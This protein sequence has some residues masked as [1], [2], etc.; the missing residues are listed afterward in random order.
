MAVFD[1]IMPGISVGA[2]QPQAP[3][4]RPISTGEYLQG[5]VQAANLEVLYQQRELQRQV[6]EQQQKD[7][8]LRRIGLANKITDPV[9]GAKILPE[10]KDQWEEL[11]SRYGLGSG[12]EMLLQSDE[13]L[14]TLSGN[15]NRFF[16]DQDVSQIIGKSQRVDAILS[17]ADKFKK[18][19]GDMYPVLLQDLE[20]AKTSYEDL[21]R[22]QVF[23]YVDPKIEGLYKDYMKDYGTTIDVVTDPETQSKLEVKKPSMTKEEAADVFIQMIADPGAQKWAQAHGYVDGSGNVNP[24]RV[25][26]VVDRYYPREFVDSATND[27]V[28][29]AREKAKVTGSGK[30]GGGSG[31][32]APDKNGRVSGKYTLLNKYE[33]LEQNLVYPLEDL[34]RNIGLDYDNNESVATQMRSIAERVMRSG[35]D[36]DTESVQAYKSILELGTKQKL[37]KALLKGAAYMLVEEQKAGTESEA[38]NLIKTD[39]SLLKKYIFTFDANTD[40]Y[41]DLIKDTIYELNGVFPQQSQQKQERKT[42]EW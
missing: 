27:P 17:Q 36:D 31:G 30:A 16:G 1:P 34:A 18:E 41:N 6:K 26:A 10:D 13:G 5:T 20:Q 19:L 8:T 25:Q 7:N 24:E 3:S 29:A 38:Y 12:Y 40:K 42:K 11:K 21:G 22:F 14:I 35:A 2:V 32:S 28:A 4:V 33:K 9:L 37:P 15:V 23:D 39:A